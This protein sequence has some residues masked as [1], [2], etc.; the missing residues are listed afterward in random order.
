MPIRELVS[1]DVHSL[2]LGEVA[3]SYVLVRRRGRRGGGL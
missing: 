2:V 3:L 1:S